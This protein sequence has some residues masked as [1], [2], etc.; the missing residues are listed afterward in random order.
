M[1]TLRAV[2]FCSMLLLAVLTTHAQDRA[3]KVRTD[4]EQL[5]QSDIWTYNDLDRGIAEAKKTK[6][7]LLVVLRCIPCEACSKFDKKLTLERN[8]EVHDLLDKFV[9]VRIVQA[10]NLDLSLFQFDYD[11]SFHAFF[12]NADRTIYGRFGTRSAREEDEDMTM[13]GLRAAMLAVLKM[14]DDYPANRASL[15]AKQGRPVEYRVPEELPALKGKYTGKLNYE[16]NVVASCIHCHQIR[17]SERELVRA[18]GKPM[19]EHVL[20][21]YPLPDV[22]GLKMNP[23]H[24][25]TI[26]TVEPDSIAA[27]AGLKPDDEIL[28]LAGQSL[29]STADLQWVLHHARSTD[30]LPA[31]VKRGDKEI[32]VSLRLPAGWRG[33]SDI[34]FRPTTW[35]LRRMA[36]GG[37]V[38]EDLGADERERHNL[39]ADRLALII[40]HVGE[41]GEHAAGKNAGFQRGDILIAVEGRAQ[42]QTE[43]Q[44]IASLLDKRPG[45]KVRMKVLRG[46][47]EL[48][49]SLPMQ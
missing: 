32:N 12:M 49:L 41:Y 3:T 24:A 23:D 21:P 22:L 47:K 34:S 18:A 2:C 15:A 27:R 48:E 39:N 40:K 44:L 16:G 1:N 31:V 29:I 43:S 37:I 28:S 33:H 20:F 36:T 26:H 19:P 17:D 6:K 8:N 38:F 9:C 30:E 5:A 4:R 7:P 10:N 14:H 46:D 42:R 11:Q 45:E 35:D 13:H 25:A